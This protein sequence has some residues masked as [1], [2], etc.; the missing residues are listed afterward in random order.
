MFWPPE[1][2]SRSRAAVLVQIEGEGQ[3]ERVRATS[4]IGITLATLSVSGC[5]TTA[6][7]QLTAGHVELSAQ[8]EQSTSVASSSSSC[9]ELIGRVHLAIAENQR[10]DAENVPI[11]GFP[12]LRANRLLSKIGERFADNPKG[13]AFDAWVDRLRSLDR[14][15]TDIEIANLP[16]DIT[17]RLAT[18]RPA[19]GSK[20]KRLAKSVDDCKNRARRV[21]LTS[22]AARRKL[23][24]S[25]YVAEDYSDQAQAVG[26]FAVTSIPVQLGWE[27]WKRDNLATF[28][29]STAEAHNGANM[30]SYAPA[31][32]SPALAPSAVRSIIRKSR[33]RYLD[34]PEPSA[35]DQKKLLQTFAPI[36]LIDDGGSYDEPGHP[37]WSKGLEVVK[38]DRQRP[39]VFTRTSHTIVDNRVLL[40][41]VYTIW[42]SERPKRSPVDL[43]GG[44]LDGVIWRVTLGDDGRP[45]IYDSI[46]VCGCYHLLFPTENFRRTFGNRSMPQINEVPAIISTSLRA[47]RGRRVVLRLAT[48]SHYLSHVSTTQNPSVQSAAAR[49]YKLSS[50]DSLRS[51]PIPTGGRRSIYGPDGIVAGS[52][53]LERFLLWQTGVQN[54]GAM[55]QWGR[56]AIAFVD[57]RHFDDPELYHQIFGR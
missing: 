44:K 16:Q 31:S 47:D 2:C 4:A 12:F 29:Q 41:L 34:I 53:R 55:R 51:L 57:R 27:N 13:P 45:L 54:P 24:R 5:A 33:D 42:F 43:L 48:A 1:S 7:E 14:K 40:Q 22:S 6:Y 50:A 20:W 56:H 3:V 35:A 17:A 52:E 19:R 8:V 23:I 18:G 32:R 26:L 21:E 11:R 25:V 46:H 30:V 36:W 49:S 15:A 39:T 28:A 37:T 10:G 38:I 9:E